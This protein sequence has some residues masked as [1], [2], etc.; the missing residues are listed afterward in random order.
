MR[1]IED[2]ELK[3][4]VIA[5][6]RTILAVGVICRDDTPKKPSLIYGHPDGKQWTQIFISA[7]G[8][9]RELEGL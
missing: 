1:D 7:R 4:Q 2:K 3:A 8:L 5:L 9:L 6:C